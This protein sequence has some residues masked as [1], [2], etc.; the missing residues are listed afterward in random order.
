MVNLILPRW[1]GL[2][3]WGH[4][5]ERTNKILWN[6]ESNDTVNQFLN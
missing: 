3:D 2:L 1:T 4:L 5:M 6:Q